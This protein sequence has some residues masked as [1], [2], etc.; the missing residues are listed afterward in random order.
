MKT[1]RT[2]AMIVAFL[3]LCLNG[4]QAQNVTPKPDQIKLMGNLWV[5]NWQ[6]IISKDSLYVTELIQYGRAFEYNVYLVV[7]G[8]KSFSFGGSYVFS[9]K[10]NDFKGFAFT[11][12]GNYQT[13]IG[14]FITETKIS[15]DIVQ[16]FNPE[17]VLIKEVVEW[18]N[19][20]TY[21]A[22]FFDLDGTKIAESKWTKVK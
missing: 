5:G 22:T 1:L 7:E 3:L 10:E 21:T 8:K 16:N 2:A 11:P 4:I 18:E 12:D 17:K 6:S 9:L 15:M 13:W 14:S 20:T 19:L